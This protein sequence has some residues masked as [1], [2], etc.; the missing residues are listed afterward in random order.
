MLPTPTD[1]VLV[2]EHRILTMLWRH[3]LGRLLHRFGTEFLY[4]YISFRFV[5]ISFLF[6]FIHIFLIINNSY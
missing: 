4:V 5:F 1:S 3:N 2:G 6:F